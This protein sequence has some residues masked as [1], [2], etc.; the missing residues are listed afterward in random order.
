MGF[1]FLDGQLGLLVVIVAVVLGR[2]P[3]LVLLL[4]F[5]SLPEEGGVEFNAAVEWVWAGVL[6]LST[7]LAP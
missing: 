5:V 1:S 4:Q 7:W 6:S 2:D 3:S